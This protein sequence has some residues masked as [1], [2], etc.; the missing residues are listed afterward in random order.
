MQKYFKHKI[1]SLLVINKVVV[2][3]SLEINEK[4]FHEEE[5]HDFWELVYVDKNQVQCTANGEAITLSQGQVLFH[6]PNEAHSLSAKGEKPTSVFV[7]S[8]DCLS[9]AMRFFT[10][11]KLNLNKRQMQYIKEIIYVA[12]RTFDTTYTSNTK[13]MPLL[14]SPI[15][16]GEQIIKNS[17]EMLLIDIMRSLTE[18]EE[19]NDVFLQESVINDKLTEDIVEILKSSVCKKLSVD[20]IAKSTNYS[21]AYIFR[22]FKKATGK[23][24]MEY[25][26]DLKIAE[27]KKLLKENTLSIREISDKLDFDTPNYFSKVF[28]K[29]TGKTPINYR[30]ERI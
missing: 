6:K 3:H 13:N 7:I 1:K 2:I 14:P 29:A 8:F 18:T 4:F 11:K 17:L 23:G 19:G 27:A 22:Q 12:Q 5:R 25:F 9:E 15:L 21:K 30:K 28:K 16:G 24:I 20:D 26:T 10:Q